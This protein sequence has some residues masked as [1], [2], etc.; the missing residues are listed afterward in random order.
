MVF[1]ALLL[2]AHTDVPHIVSVPLAA[3]VS[4]D[5]RKGAALDDL[6]YYMWIP[7]YDGPSNLVIDLE[8]G[9]HQY[10]RPLDGSFT[11]VYNNQDNLY[12]VSLNNRF[13]NQP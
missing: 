6:D 5:E 3:G 10:N 2:T 9:R 8:K 11:F 12:E 1:T 13:L 7:D 4:Y